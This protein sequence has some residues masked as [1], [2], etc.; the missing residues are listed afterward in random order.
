M[1]R[2]MGRMLGRSLASGLL[3]AVIGVVLMGPLAASAQ[4]GGDGPGVVQAGPAQGI[5]ARG[6]GEAS[7]PADSA[8]MQFIV[9]STQ[10]GQVKDPTQAIGQEGVAVTS[11]TMGL[12]VD[13]AKSKGIDDKSIDTV[14]VPSD[15]FSTPFGPGVGVL[16]VQLDKAEI[17]HRMKI[18]D[19]VTKVAKDNGLTFDQIGVAYLVDDCLGLDQAAITD[20]AKDAHDQAA[21]MAEVMSLT[22]GDLIAVETQP[23]YLGYGGGSGSACGDPPTIDSAKE[24]Y[25]PTFNADGK[26]EQEIYEYLTLTYAIG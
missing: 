11:E 2:V 3:V 4:G 23:S 9:R 24:I 8:I 1:S 5:T 16:V 20:A 13:A 6:N 14:I 10:S 21:M 17:K 12:L 22:L 19:A 7:A 26:A 15:A 25:L 18:A